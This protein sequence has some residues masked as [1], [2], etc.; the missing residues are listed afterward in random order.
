MLGTPLYSIAYTQR[1]T[2][3]LAPRKVLAKW[4]NFLGEAQ[5][6]AIAHN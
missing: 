6:F 2:M 4:Q 5:H 1:C 3:R